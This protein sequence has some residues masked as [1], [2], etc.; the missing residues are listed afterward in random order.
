[1][2]HSPRDTA[3]RIQTHGFRKH[4][5]RVKS[6]FDNAFDSI[7]DP[8]VYR[9]NG[10]HKKTRCEID[11]Q[12]FP[13]NVAEF[14]WVYCNP[15]EDKFYGLCR[16][17]SGFYAYFRLVEQGFLDVKDSKFVVSESREDLIQY[18]MSAK[19]YHKYL[20]KTEPNA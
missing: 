2:S 10:A 15:A 18:A 4:L 14:Y 3:Q 1:M 11:I 9:L 20:K 13:K 8:V 6:V 5:K 16:L 17:T 7:Q 19:A 12:S